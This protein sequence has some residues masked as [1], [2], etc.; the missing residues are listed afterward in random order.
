MNRRLHLLP[1]NQLP[2]PIERGDVGSIEVAVSP[3]EQKQL[4]TLM[5][6]A[7]R[8][9]MEEQRCVLTVSPQTSPKRNCPCV[10]AGPDSDKFFNMLAKSQGKRLDDQRVCLPSL[11]GI[12]NGGSTHKDSSYLCYMVSKVQVGGHL[13]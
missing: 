2:I 8:G 9:R 5:S 1:G 12:Q 3:A 4:L 13:S 11:P 6:H 10:R 7:Q